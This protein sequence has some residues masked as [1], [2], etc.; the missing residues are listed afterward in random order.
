M[1]FG[2]TEQNIINNKTSKTKETKNLTTQQN[3]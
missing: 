3:F 2:K 1:D